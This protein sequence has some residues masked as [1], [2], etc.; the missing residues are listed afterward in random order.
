MC[1]LS[2]RTAR[3]SSSTAPKCTVGGALA[4]LFRLRVTDQVY[5]LPRGMNI[6]TPG[7]FAEGEGKAEGR[8]PA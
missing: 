5:I 2:K 7:V 6:C 8:I 4:E 1:A 3:Q